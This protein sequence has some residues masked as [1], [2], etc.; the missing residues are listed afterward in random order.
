MNPI[1]D[2]DFSKELLPTYSKFDENDK[3]KQAISKMANLSDNL[4]FLAYVRLGV[5]SRK[6]KGKADVF[7]AFQALNKK[8]LIRPGTVKRLAD[9]NSLTPTQMSAFS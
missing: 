7:L 9:G 6:L 8:H 3:L 4:R 2:P 5:K 1:A